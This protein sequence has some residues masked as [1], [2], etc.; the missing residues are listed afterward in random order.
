MGS[1]GAASSSKPKIRAVSGAALALWSEQMN[2]SILKR[3]TAPFFVI[4]ASLLLS[5]PGTTFGQ[6]GRG[7]APPAPLTPKANAPEDISGYWV[8][9]VTE[10]WRFRMVTPAKGDY[11]SVPLSAEGRRVADMWDPAKDEAAG[12]QCKSYGAGAIVRVPGAT[13]YPLFSRMPC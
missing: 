2:S 9:L 11:A 4:V 12:D 5:L 6:A 13:R 7:A 8:S 1:D 3:R 10:D